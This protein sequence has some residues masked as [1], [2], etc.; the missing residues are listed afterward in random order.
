MMKK[1]I[2]FDLDGTLLPMDQDIFVKTYFGYLAKKLAPYG[3]E[4][5]QLIDVIWKGTAAMVKNTGPK[6]NEEVFWD[7]FT[8]VYGLEKKESDYDKFDEFY[9]M[10]F[11]K[12]Q[13]VCGFQPLAKDV[14]SF[15]K[16][17]GYTL[18]LAT[19]PLFPA[20]AVKQRMRWAGIDSNDFTL[21]TTYEDF[22]A[23]KPN[24]QYFQEILDKLKLQPEDCVMIG[25]DI[26]EDV[27]AKSIGIDVFLVTDC[28]INTKDVDITDIPR[29]SFEDIRKYIEQL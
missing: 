26:Q 2:L 23:C 11:C 27:A 17:K 13:S 18:V 6:S 19:N 3:Y 7:Y 5:S 10:E 14:V 25:N 16:S 1:A 28:L 22:H 4:A 29:G 9:R 24:P 12:A 20:I 21:I 15:A 8:S